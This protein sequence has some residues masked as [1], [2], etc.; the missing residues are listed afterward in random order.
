MNAQTPPEFISAD[1]LPARIRALRDSGHRLVQIGATRLPERVEVIYSLDRDTQLTNLRVHLDPV[2]PR[3]ASI[4]SIYGCAVLY[5]NELHD[6][7]KIQVDGM[8]LDFHGNLY[9]TSV[10]FP[11]G[12]VKAPTAKPAPA[13]AKAAAPAQKPA[14]AS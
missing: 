6:L 2:A 4:S 13:P 8:A 10:K 1:A 11:F 7:F 12:T 9:K 3:L 14:P 5:E